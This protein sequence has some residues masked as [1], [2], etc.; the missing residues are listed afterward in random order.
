MIEYTKQVIEDIEDYINIGIS[1]SS[2][3]DH[4]I[5]L[6]KILTVARKI[7]RADAGTLFFYENDKLEFKIIQNESLGIS[8]GIY[9]EKIS[10]PPVEMNEKNVAA[11]S[12]I[13]NKIVNI[14]DVYNDKSF[15]FS[16]PYKY[17]N[18]TGYHTQSILVIPLEDNNSNVIGVLQLINAKDN[19]GSIIAFENH[20]ERIISALGSQAAISLA[21]MN[22]LQDIT[23]LFDSF[24][25]VIITA[26][27]A[28]TPYNVN[29]A[30]NIAYNAENFAKYLNINNITEYGYF[31]DSRI[32]Q[33]VMAAW[34]HDVGK[35][36][37]PHE[38]MEKPTR[39]GGKYE[40]VSLRLDFIESQLLLKYSE[41]SQY[42]IASLN[43]LEE[44]K[45]EI[46]FVRN[47]KSF[48]KEVNEPSFI[49][50]NNIK[51]K[52]LMLGKKQYLDMSKQIKSWLTLDEV[53]DLSIEKG[54]LSFRE[55][56]IMQ[57]H[58]DIG[59]RML[60]KISFKNYYSNVPLWAKDHHEFLDGTGYPR[61]KKGGQIPTEVRI[62][63][64]LDI[65]DALVAKDR[66]YKKSMTIEKALITLL[67]M[68]YENKLDIGLVKI[69]AKSKIW[70]MDSNI[71]SEYFEKK[72]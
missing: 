59:E 26:I 72:I 29:H 13:H 14:N 6:E 12:A 42:K 32:K 70:E 35:I 18:I 8:A 1:L 2:E 49:V 50:N 43:E 66:P 15:D 51:E 17:D 53:A 62:L 4:N 67:E 24:I 37:I 44:I 40:M 38:I 41:K 22:Y 48:V 45:C 10:L 63:T 64:I 7:T 65:F 56:L 23:G 20:Y 19:D 58:V 39:L 9:G 16:G 34:V 27:D 52:I 33:L 30:K 31:D 36:A 68:G 57:G 60:D 61:G 25:Q 3:K 69:F 28:Q 47:S 5:L 11:Y 55:R 71:G 21:N 54:T 46:E